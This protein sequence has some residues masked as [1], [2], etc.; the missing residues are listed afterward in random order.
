MHKWFEEFV[1]ERRYLKGV[2]PRTQIWYQ[3]A[4]HLLGQHIITEDGDLVPSSELAE[5][6][7]E[8]R[9]RGVSPVSVNCWGRALN[10]YLKW[11]HDE[12]HLSIRR[13]IPKL[14]EEKKILQTLRP[15]QIDALLRW[16][17]WTF[18]ERRL[19]ALM[20]MLLDTGLRID[21][22]FNLCRNDIDI[23]NLLVTVRHG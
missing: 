21:E 13:R 20:A 6:I 2:S 8:M 5:R 19:H 11:A 23:D 15:A 22:A 4:W 18:G 17:P 3:H 14:K 12:G 16:R 9:E 7:G 10:A 1:R